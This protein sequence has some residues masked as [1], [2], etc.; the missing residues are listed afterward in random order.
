MTLK[1]NVLKREESY[2]INDTESMVGKRESPSTY[3]SDQVHSHDKVISEEM[4]LVSRRLNFMFDSVRPKVKESPP[5]KSQTFIIA[6][7]DSIL[8]NDTQT[9]ASDLDIG[10]QLIQYSPAFF[11]KSTG[12]HDFR[13]RDKLYELIDQPI[14]KSNVKSSNKH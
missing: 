1:H 14:I 12:M 8:T 9:A 13:E 11:L 3:S 10:D 7:L 2:E 5:L 6:K 4:S